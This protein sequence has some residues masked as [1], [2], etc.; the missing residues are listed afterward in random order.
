MDWRFGGILLQLLNPP[1]RIANRSIAESLNSRSIPNLSITQWTRAA[2]YRP[3]VVVLDAHADDAELP[4][5]KT[6]KA[7]RDVVVRTDR[8]AGCAHLDSLERL[9]I[10]PSVV[11]ADAGSKLVTG[12]AVAHAAT[13]RARPRQ[14]A[15]SRAMGRRDIASEG[16]EDPSQPPRTTPMRHVP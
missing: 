12:V 16:T 14:A 4:G 5:A 11:H 3:D 6:L 15:A 1:I 9:G 8:G 10:R 2:G 7:A 13:V